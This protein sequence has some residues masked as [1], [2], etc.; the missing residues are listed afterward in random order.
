MTVSTRSDPAW[1]R[2]SDLE[3]A[4]A[5]LAC[6]VIS[7]IGHPPDGLLGL[8]PDGLRLQISANALTVP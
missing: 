2:Q 5:P 6:S 8:I 1:K 7:L 3:K 4:N